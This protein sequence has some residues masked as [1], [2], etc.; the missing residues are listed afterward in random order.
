MY[1][2]GVASNSSPILGRNMLYYNKSYLTGETMPK[3]KSC[4]KP[5]IKGEYHKPCYKTKMDTT[6]FID[7]KMNLK[8]YPVKHNAPMRDDTKE[9]H[10]GHL[11]KV[12][13]VR[14]ATDWI[15]N[16]SYDDVDMEETFHQIMEGTLVL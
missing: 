12:L 2:N 7:D 11:Y 16:N 14:A 3:C 4:D 13:G 10:Y 9:E 5:V 15:V 1:P 8:T 6:N